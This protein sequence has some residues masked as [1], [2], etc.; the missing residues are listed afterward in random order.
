MGSSIFKNNEIEKNLR[1][2]YSAL[3]G[4]GWYIW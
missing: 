3:K 2:I 4:E 1:E